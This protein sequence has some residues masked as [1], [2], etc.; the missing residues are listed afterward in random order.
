MILTIERGSVHCRIDPMRYGYRATFLGMLSFLLGVTCRYVLG[1]GSEQFFE[2]ARRFAAARRFDEAE[3]SLRRLL[4]REPARTEARLLLGHLAH[5][6]GDWAT[7]AAVFRGIPDSD[8]VAGPIRVAEGD[9]WLQLNRAVLAE[10][11]WSRAHRLSPEDPQPRGRLIYVYGLQ[12]RR[13]PWMRLLWELY[14]RDQAGLGEMIQ[15]MIAGHVVWEAEEA[16]QDVGRFA[17]ADAD[18]VNSR[19]AVGEYRLLAGQFPKAIRELESILQSKP[20]DLETRLALVEC[21]LGRADNESARTCLDQ[22]SSPAPADYRFWKDRGSLALLDRRLDDSVTDFAKA[23]ANAP[24]DR[25]LHHKMAQSLRLVGNF[26]AAERHAET[27]DKLARIHRL[28][29]SLHFQRTPSLPE[30]ERL[31][32]LCEESGLIEEALGWIRVGLGLEQGNPDL[33]AARHRLSGISRTSSR[34]PPVREDLR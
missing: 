34:H 15:L 9:A 8:P 31:V 2:Q 13:E 26:D 18:D 1:H 24:F 32:Q 19:R 7:V 14:D 6:R 11:C 4:A 16:V 27:A 23:L 29:H 21:H 22:I 10:D 3:M 25:E 5:E 28:C 33:L 30:I 17:A 20:D 12:L